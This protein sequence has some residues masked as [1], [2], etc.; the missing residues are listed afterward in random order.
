MQEN[1]I[2]C[3]QHET[4]LPKKQLKRIL[5]WEPYTISERLSNSVLFYHLQKLN[6]SL[7]VKQ[8][9]IDQVGLLASS[10]EYYGKNTC[11]HICNNARGLYLAGCFFQ[12]KS[13]QQL[14]IEILY[15]EIPKFVTSEG[16]LREGSSHYQFIF[17]RWIAEILHFS[18]LYNDENLS[19]FLKPYFELL[20]CGCE[21]FLVESQKEMDFPLIGDVSPDF[22]P[23]WLIGLPNF[24]NRMNN[25]KNKNPSWQNLWTNSNVKLKL[26]FN[27]KSNSKLSKTSKIHS[28]SGWYRFQYSNFIMFLR[29]EKKVYQTM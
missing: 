18:H 13:A 11:N 7:L 9:L 27:K 4:N 15:T 16:F 22:S 29:V 28:N 19:T 2:N 17:T 26:D 12:I 6:P 20:I 1:W 5:H 21:F 25:S 24:I 8:S 3:F 23:K 10:L 14:G